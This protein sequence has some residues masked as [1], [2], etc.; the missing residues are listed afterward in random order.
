MTD[1]E[2]WGCGYCRNDGRLNDLGVCPKC[3]AEYYPDKDREPPILF[4][5]LTPP[6]HQLKVKP[7]KLVLRRK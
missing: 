6:S 3:D 4:S 1:E 5:D 2:D 7:G